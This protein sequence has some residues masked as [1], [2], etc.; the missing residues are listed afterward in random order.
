MSR[1]ISRLIRARLDEER[2]FTI[3]EMVIA[4]GVIFASL[5]ALM[6][7]ATSGFR[8]MALARERQ[9]A[10]GAATRIMEQI[11]ALS[12][13]TITDGMKTSDLAGDPKIKTPTDCGDGAYHFETCAGEEIVHGAT[14]ANVV[15]LV[16]HT[17][18]LSA[19]EYPTTYT[20]ATY[21]TNSDPT[22]DPYRL[23][24]I[25]SWTGGSVDGAAK[26]IQVQS[27]WTSP[28]G[29]SASPVIHPFAGPCQPYFN[30]SATAAQG[31]IAITG[32]VNGTAISDATL[33]GAQA[34]ARGATEQVSQMQGTVGQG[35]ASWNG[36]TRGL[37]ALSFAAD[38]NPSTSTGTY[39]PA[40]GVP[41]A[42]ITPTYGP[43]IAV[44]ASPVA[45]SLSA[46]SSG[47]SGSAVAADA[48]NTSTAKC[49]SVSS[50]W[51]AY[52]SDS[53]PCAWG[54]AVRGATMT[55]TVN[56]TKLLGTTSASAGLLTLAQLTGTATIDSWADRQV[57]SGTTGTLEMSARRTIGTMELIGVPAK[58]LAVGTATDTNTLATTTTLNALNACTGGYYLI[59]A[60]AGTA[61]AVAKTGVSAANP[62]AAWTGAN[63]KLYTGA[64]C[65]TYADAQLNASSPQQPAF[66]GITLQRAVRVSGSNWNCITY[67]VTTPVASEPLLFGGAT[68]TK[69]PSS[70][71]TLT[72]ATA[73]VSPLVQGTIKVELIYETSQNS[74][75]TSGSA[76]KEWV[77]D[78]NVKPSLGAL[79]SR[80]Q[81]IAPPT[82]G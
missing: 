9:A 33:F 68:T 70:G 51:P 14:T 80:S 52:Q 40:A 67:K 37:A 17:G 38:G 59:R 6:Y 44:T 42:S 46:G 61:N 55:A 25:V 26:F 41:P 71:T 76:V 20:W 22:N 27:L 45:M 82:G 15:P 53:L 29:C 54:R 3:L 60:T 48:A 5:T 36:V 12:V 57:P 64:A 63:V 18:T 77:V 24:V 69:L 65:T 73:T 56:T 81:Y 78:V 2:G 32:T 79:T 7:T 19:P 72:D 1:H 66:T 4:M 62:T 34:E 23:T 39:A 43:A 74:G 75:C 47:D 49:P 35:G 31:S 16:P 10:T 13:E 8:Y 21:V 30:G 11:H 58:F 50:P 28:K